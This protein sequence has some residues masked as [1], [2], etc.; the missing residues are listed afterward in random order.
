MYHTIKGTILSLILNNRDHRI[1][2]PTTGI[3]QHVGLETFAFI[4][5]NIC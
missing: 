5:N 3:L 4:S 1:W 2:N